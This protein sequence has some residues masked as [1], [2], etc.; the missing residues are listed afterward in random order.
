MDPPRFLEP[1]DI[2]SGEI[3]GIGRITNEVIDDD[4]GGEQQ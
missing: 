3:E 2:V 4:A 1:G